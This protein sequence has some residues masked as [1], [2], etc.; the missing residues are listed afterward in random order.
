MKN[1]SNKFSLNF[2]VLNGWRR[3]LVLAGGV[4]LL[5]HGDHC[6]TVGGSQT[7]L[8]ARACLGT[9]GVNPVLLHHDAVA[10]LLRDVVNVKIPVSAGQ[11]QS[12]LPAQRGDGHDVGQSD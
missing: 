2:W 1:K 12:G 6:G 7:G 11:H 5:G 10:A 3:R 8:L 9:L 4:F